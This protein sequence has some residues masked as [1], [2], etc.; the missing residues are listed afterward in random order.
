MKTRLCCAAFLLLVLLL[1]PTGSGADVLGSEVSDCM[2]TPACQSLLQLGR[3]QSGKGNLEDAE[4]LYKAAYE[5]R[6]DPGLLFNIARVLHKRGRAQEAATYYQQ[7]LNSRIVNSEQKRKAQE[8]LNELQPSDPP[9]SFPPDQTSAPALSLNLTSEYISSHV[10][11]Q[12]PL[13]K[14]DAGSPST[15]L[16]KKWWLW[17]FIGGTVAVAAA[18]GC[19]AW[20]AS[21]PPSLPDGINTYE[22]GF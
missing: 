19:G 3:A 13:A 21:R 6:A 4:R 10:S 17:A 15:P 1:L 18:V 12:S 7:F 22:P 14:P 9:P 8:Y 2:N 11:P 5:V 20:G 16:Y